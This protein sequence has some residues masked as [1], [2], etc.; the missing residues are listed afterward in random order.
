MKINAVMKTTVSLTEERQYRL[1]RQQYRE[2][3]RQSL[4]DEAAA[5]VAYNNG[6]F[7]WVHLGNGI[8]A[9]K[10][11][12]AARDAAGRV[13]RKPHTQQILAGCLENLMILALSFEEFSEHASRLQALAPREAILHQ[14]FPQTRQW[15]SEGLPWSEV[16]TRRSVDYWNVDRRLD[17]GRY[18]CAASILHLLLTHRATLRVNRE[19]Y[20]AWLHTYATLLFKQFNARMDEQERRQGAANEWELNVIFEPALPLLETYVASHVSDQDLVS[21]LEGVREMVMSMDHYKAVRSKSARIPCALHLTRAEPE[22]GGLRLVYQWA[23]SLP[24]E[25][26]Q[27]IE[28]RACA[29]VNSAIG[30]AAIAQWVGCGGG[31]SPASVLGVPV[32]GWYLEGESQATYVR[33]SQHDVSA[34]TVEMRI[35]ASSANRNARPGRNGSA[36]GAL[37][38]SFETLFSTITV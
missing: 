14:Q 15:E 3:D 11:F 8:E 7:H 1:A 32:P 4:S 17:P 5:M 20:R 24:S 18:A 16:M 30:I 21:K 29:F 22:G 37:Q 33:N 36:A 27:V 12:Q 19:M 13:P 35:G 9:R 34:R 10:Q 26:A 28:T 6:V 31:P 25:E 38:E 23:E 2:L